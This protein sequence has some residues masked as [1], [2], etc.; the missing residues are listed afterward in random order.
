MSARPSTDAIPAELRDEALAEQIAA[1]CFAPNAGNGRVEFEPQEFEPEE[2]EV[3][4]LEA[5]AAVDEPGADPLVGDGDD[6]LIPENGD[7]MVYGDGGAGK[8]TLSLDA[9]FH[10][11]A[12]DDWLGVKVPRRV[13]VLVIEGEG[14]RALF[15]KKAKRKLAAWTGSPLEGRIG[16]L[17]EPWAAGTFADGSWRTALAECVREQ[18]IDVVIAGPVTRLGMD[19]AGTL[20]QVRDFT[21]L[22]GDVRQRAG[23]RLTSWLVHHENKGGTVS[24]AWEGAGDT[25]L[26]VEARGPGHTHL[27]VQKARWSSKHHGARFDLA[28]TDGEGFEVVEHERDHA[29][30]IAAL[31]SD[32]KWR[33]AKEI[34]T[35]RDKPEPG[36]GA[37]V[38]TVKVALD[39]RRDIFAE[40]TGDAAIEVGRHPNATVYGLTSPQKSDKSD[41][42]FQ[43]SAG[44][45]LTSDFPLRESEGPRSDPTAQLGLT[46]A[47][48]SDESDSQQEAGP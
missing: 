2:F 4:T 5:F 14:P 10:L 9:G 26:H 35:P 47:A 46:S 13:R 25:L 30:E 32:G 22:I 34:A 16:I 28:W 3:V 24:G 33:T 19:E 7:V 6:A 20:Q 27:H 42:V 41:G 39:R 11:A 43:G 12:G 15:R 18:R 1:E 40:R 23:R 37:A 17:A 8:T 44:E 48:K 31:L 45:G 21:A 36:I 38:E 29:A